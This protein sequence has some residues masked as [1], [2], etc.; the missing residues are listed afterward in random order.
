MSSNQKISWQK[1]E[2]DCKELVDDL[3][4]VR[5]NIKNVYGLPRG[6]LVIAVIIS[7]LLNVVVITDKKLITEKT[8]V[9]DD[10]SDTGETLEALLKGKKHIPI[11]ATLWRDPETKFIPNYYVNLKESNWLQFPWETDQ[12]TK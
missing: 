9:V 11:T 1:V 4:L 8:L 3:V 2:Q 5:E 12:T 7:H 10:I 6:G